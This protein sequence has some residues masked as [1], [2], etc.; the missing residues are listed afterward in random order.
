MISQWRLIKK[1]KKKTRKKKTQK[2]RR[3]RKRNR[4]SEPRSR[5]LGDQQSKRVKVI[6]KQKKTA[7]AHKVKK[8]Q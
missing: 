8:G 1:K 4:R 5:K 2:G 7:M 3:K 6:N